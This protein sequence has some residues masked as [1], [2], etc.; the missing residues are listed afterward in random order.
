MNGTLCPG[1]DGTLHL[2]VGRGHFRIAADDTRA[3]LAGGTVVPVTMDETGTAEDGTVGGQ[4]LIVGHAAMN[5]F[6]RSVKIFTVAGHFIVPLVSVQRVVRGE[7]ASA[8][9]FPL[10]PEGCP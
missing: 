8:P 5:H 1:P 6:E 4:T 7:A 3:L 2:F 10:V 9:L